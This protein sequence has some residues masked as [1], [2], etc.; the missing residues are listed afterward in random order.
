MGLARN[1]SKG[2]GDPSR[3][4]GDANS[5]YVFEQQNDVRMD[6]LGSKISALKSVCASYG[7]KGIQEL[8]KRFV[9]DNSRYAPRCYRSRPVAW[10]IGTKDSIIVTL[11]S[12]L[13]GKIEHCVW[14]IGK[15]AATFIRQDESHDIYPAQAAALFL[16]DHCCRCV[17]NHILGLLAC[18]TNILVIIIA[19][20]WNTR[21][22]RDCGSGNVAA[23]C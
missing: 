19:H 3:S 5:G 9:T 14:W 13:T 10:R 15:H 23:F 2:G 18:W 20:S 4:Q 11:P 22:R 6:E 21:W 17:S 16:R 1:N 8:L 12:I 7:S